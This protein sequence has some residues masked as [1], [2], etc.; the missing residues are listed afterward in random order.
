MNPLFI[1]DT[2][3]IGGEFRHYNPKVSIAGY[4]T[5]SGHTVVMKH[6]T[7][8]NKSGRIEAIMRSETKGKLTRLFCSRI[9][10]TF[11][12]TCVAAAAS[13]LARD[14]T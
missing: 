9:F 2:V 13:R 1:R 11:P 6:A 10:S 14:R 5:S 12:L 3:L 7:S 4:G 8:T